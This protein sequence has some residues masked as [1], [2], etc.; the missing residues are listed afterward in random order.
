[1]RI[2]P[3][4]LS[5]LVPILLVAACGTGETTSG[6]APALVPADA[7]DGTAP[8]DDTGNAPTTP[9]PTDDAD[10]PAPSPEDAGLVETECADGI[11][12]DRDGLVDCADPDCYEAPEC[13]GLADIEF[14]CVDGIDNDGNGLTDCDDPACAR[15]PV[16]RSTIEPDAGVFDDTSVDPDVSD[17]LVPPADATDGDDPDTS[18][19]GG[20]IPPIPFE[21]ECDDGIDND[22]DGLIDCDD[23]DCEFIPPCIT[24]GG[25]GLPPIPFEFQCDDGIDN[26]RDGLIDCDDPDCR[27][28][29]PCLFRG[30]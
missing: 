8:G 18:G 16:C 24:G 11:D 13:E 3:S 25:S 6:T 21:F 23:P 5:A 30:P 9:A 27:W 15:S 4:R 17:P 20:L 22:R 29:P 28:I 19:G 2:R 26:D 1:M 12:N 10:A 7:T 14:N